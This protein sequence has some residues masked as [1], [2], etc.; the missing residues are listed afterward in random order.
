M[1]VAALLLATGA[2][3]P[4]VENEVAL[5]KQIA[6]AD[7]AP[8]LFLCDPTNRQVMAVA[9]GPQAWLPP[10]KAFDNLWY[11]GTNFVGTYLLKTSAGLMLIDAL[12]SEQDVRQHLE[13]EMRALG[14]DPAD[15][16]YAI[17]THA[18]WD[19]FGGA[20]YL[21]E[22]Y[23]TRIAMSG[24]DWALLE[25]SKPGDG[26]RSGIDHVDRPPPR[27]DIVIGD[28]RKLT[29]G[30]TGISLLL[31]PGHSPGTL[32]T[33]IPARENGQTYVLSLLGGTMIPPQ[34]EPI[35]ASGGV[36]AF[37]RSI[38]RLS[39]ASRKAGAVGL[40]NTHIFVDGTDT[41]LA[42]SRKRLAGAPNPFVIGT[43]TVVRYYAMFRACVKAAEL[44]A[45][46]KAP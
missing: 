27:R 12:M 36:L 4:T 5:A 10:T 11:F 3:V 40:L 18:H 33:L 2:A 7:L 43:A 34:L 17:I 35:N 30:D 45:L 31:T 16:R 37:E 6:G 38:V 21:Q 39:D 25:R 29:L 13:P 20:R 14:F 1:A 15:I 19:H 24:P 8:S 23:G 9:T 41:R 22:R 26:F 44:R 32:S 46:T 42:Q 28:G